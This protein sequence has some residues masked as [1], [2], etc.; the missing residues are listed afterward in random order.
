MREF[1]ADRPRVDEFQLPQ[2]VAQLHPLRYGTTAA[3]GE[4]FRVQVSV[5]QAEVAQIEHS[6]PWSASQAQ[7]V[8]PG[9]QVTAIGPDLDE[10]RDGRLLGR[11]VRSRRAGTGCRERWYAR[12][13]RPLSDSRL[14]G[15]MRPLTGHRRRH[16]LKI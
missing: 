5:G 10:A 14:D 9:H 16:A 7:R 8:N 11:V 6:G 1:G 4:E 2:N 3:A 15:A 12:R 13:A